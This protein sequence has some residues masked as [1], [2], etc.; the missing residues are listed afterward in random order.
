MNQVYGAKSA[1]RP[2]LYWSRASSRN[3]YLV[4]RRG[5]KT[6]TDGGAFGRG[7]S[8]HQE[9]R[10]DDR[11]DDGHDS[12]AIVPALVVV[13][14]VGVHDKEGIDVDLARDAVEVRD[15]DAKDGA[16]EARE[17]V[18]SVVDHLGAAVQI[19]RRD[20]NLNSGTRE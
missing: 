20:H 17:G 12:S 15:H 2:T 4:S 1:A 8:I 9:A 14:G 18:K 16:D 19:P 11:G 6:D 10:D 5:V 7:V 3:P 13:L